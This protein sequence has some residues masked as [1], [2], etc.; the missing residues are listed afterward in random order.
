MKCSINSLCDKDVISVENGRNIGTVSDVEFDTC[1]FNCDG[2]AILVY[3]QSCDLTVKNCVFNDN[4]TIADKAAIEVCNGDNGANC[5]THNVVV[6][7][8][9]VNGFDV[10]PNGINTNSTL[11]ANKNSL[12]DAHLNVTIDGVV[13]Y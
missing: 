10:N 9:T 8:T 3:N 5:V 4:G 12:D 13:V 11:W 6:T 1:T 7:N 2:K